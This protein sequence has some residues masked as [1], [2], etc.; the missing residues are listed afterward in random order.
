MTMTTATNA[1]AGH[2]AG[3]QHSPAA[4]GHEDHLGERREQSSSTTP[5]STGA[6]AKKPRRALYRAGRGSVSTR[7]REG[8]ADDE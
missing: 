6:P 8:A 4:G 2:A 1:T 3:P 7:A 5:S